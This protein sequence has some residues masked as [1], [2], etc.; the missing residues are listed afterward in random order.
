MSIVGL[1]LLVRRLGVTID[2]GEAGEIGGN[3]MAIVADRAMVGNLEVVGVIK[4]GAEPAGS[5]VAAGGVA[6]CWEAGGNVVRYAAAKSLRAVP[7]CNVATVADRVCGGQGVVAADVA[8]RAS[9][10]AA[11]RGRN[12]MAAGQRPARGAVIEFAVRPDRDGMATGACDSAV[13]EIG[14]DVIGHVRA[15]R[16]VCGV[17]RGKMAAEAI[18]VRRIQIVAVANMTAHARGG[19]VGAHESEARGAMVPGRLPTGGV[20]ASG[21]LRGREASRN[22][23]WNRSA[24]CR[25]GVVGGLVTTVAVGIAGV[26]FVVAGDVAV[27]ALLYAWRS[28]RHHVATGQRPARRAVIEFTVGPY[29][30]GVARCASRGRGGEVR[31]DVVR[32]VAAEGRSGVP[33]SLVASEAIYIVGIQL[34]VIGNVAACAGRGRVRA[35][36]SEAGGRVIPCGSPTYGVVAGRTLVCGETCFHVVRDDAAHG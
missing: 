10:Y 25:G 26:E 21:A 22:V 18:G 9:L 16:G 30:D 3:L 33:G 6:S 5:G 28:G 17:P 11:V 14:S 20:V 23:I 2:T 7:L 34:V 15:G 19:C 35:D 27:R 36:Q 24:H 12:D 32:D 31:L 1:R 29:S 8:I 4:S 13:R